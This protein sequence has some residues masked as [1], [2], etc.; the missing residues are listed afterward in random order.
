VSP[1]IEARG[2][3]VGYTQPVLRGLDW[4]AEAGQLWAVLGPNGAGKSTLL[5]TCL[6]LLKPSAGSVSVLGRAVQAWERQSLAQR[7]AWV[8]QQFHAD[9]GFT[10]LEVVLM[11]R[12]PHLGHWGI[13]SGR[14]VARA[15]AALEE[16]GVASLASRRTSELSGG[17]QRLVW[18]ARALTQAP[19]LLL[20]D[21]PTAFLDLKH[22]AEALSRLSRRVSAGLCVA[23]VLHDV[24]LAAAFADHVLLLRNGEVLASGPARDVLT[25]ERVE[26]LYGVAMSVARD[27][28]GQP[29]FAPRRPA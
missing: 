7:L 22:Q 26:S 19:E 17:E 27:E 13:P 8:P 21:E 11:G 18:L 3:T 2:L 28:A 9:G 1:V 20:L 16:L 14:D 4:T 24:N 12:S 6:G 29:L 15:E 5:K 25:Q 10:A 23:A